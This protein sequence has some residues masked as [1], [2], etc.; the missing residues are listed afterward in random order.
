M[1]LKDSI[2][3]VLDLCVKIVLVIVAIYFIHKYALI[4]YDYGYRVFN[5]PPLTT[6]TGRVV[7]VSVAEDMSPVEIGE[8]LEEKKLVADAKLFVLQYYCSEY[9]DDVKPGVFRLSSSMTG[10]EMMAVMAGVVTEEEESEE[11]R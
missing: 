6:G 9:K 5:E 8:L 10:E 3:S 7:T 4:C 11:A 1:K 2:G